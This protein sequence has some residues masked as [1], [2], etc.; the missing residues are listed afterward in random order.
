MAAI[1]WRTS[2]RCASAW[3]GRREHCGYQLARVARLFGE[4]SLCEE[5]T[6]VV[7]FLAS[8]AAGYVS[9]PAIEVNDGRYERED[10]GRNGVE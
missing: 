7:L 10:V 2:P 6:A 5:V 3:D 9:A 4:P 1:T 8:E